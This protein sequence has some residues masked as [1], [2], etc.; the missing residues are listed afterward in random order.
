M[1]SN[2]VRS[3]GRFSEKPLTGPSPQHLGAIQIFVLSAPS[4]L[5]RTALNKDCTHVVTEK[6]V[7]HAQRFICTCSRFVDVWKDL[8]FRFRLPKGSD[9]LCVLTNSARF[10]RCATSCEKRDVKLIHDFHCKLWCSRY[11]HTPS[12]PWRRT[13]V[14]FK[15]VPCWLTNSIFGVLTVLC[16][17][18]SFK[19]TNIA[20]VCARCYEH[21]VGGLWFRHRRKQK[22]CHV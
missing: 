19:Y 18:R 10:R 16:W 9:A 5:I 1:C 17:S 12:P 14:F 22:K 7:R 21:A 3:Q 8:F 11:I 6:G 2:M 4:L 15:T 13:L 20:I